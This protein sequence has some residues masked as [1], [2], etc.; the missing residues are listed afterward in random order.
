V[1]AT[2]SRCSVLMRLLAGSLSVL[3]PA[4][5]SQHRAGAQ[6]H[7]ITSCS[8]LQRTSR[9]M[10][11]RNNENKRK[12]TLH[13]DRWMSVRLSTDVPFRH[14]LTLSTRDLGTGTLATNNIYKLRLFG[15][16]QATKPNRSTRWL[17]NDAVLVTEV[18]KRRMRWKDDDELWAGYI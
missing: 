16:G 10:I 12:T 6:L 5:R 18:S 2:V 9:D 1:R 11:F 8:V 17:F 3:T 14:W 15:N 7:N 13:C 4:A